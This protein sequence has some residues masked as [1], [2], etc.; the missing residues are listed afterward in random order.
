L[1]AKVVLS[2]GFK[3][4]IFIN[5]TVFQIQRCHKVILVAQMAYQHRIFR[6][7]RQEPFVPR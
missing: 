7:F 6:G 2:T 5:T 1:V 3:K 4:T